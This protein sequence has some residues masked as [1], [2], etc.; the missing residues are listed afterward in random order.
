ML[1][2][3]KLPLLVPLVTAAMM[4]GTVLAG[5]ASA[6][7]SP[8]AQAQPA[9][10]RQVS[11]PDG[12]SIA[13]D[14]DGTATRTDAKGKVLAK[15]TLALPLGESALGESWAPTD[16]AVR[17]AFTNR[18]APS[19]VLAV[20][21]GNTAITGAPVAGGRRA[22][23]TS[24]AGLN[25]AF[26][27]VGAVSVQPLSDEPSLAK[28]F[29]VHLKGGDPAAA[30]KTL[31]ATP[32]IASAQPDRTISAMST[33]PV[34]FP[35]AAQKAAKAQSH[36]NPP[37]GLPDNYGLTSSAQSFLNAGGTDAVGAYSLLQNKF[38]QLP[39]TGEIITNVSI[40]DLT[41]QS[42]ADAGDAYVQQSGPT[43]I[44]QNGQRYLDLPSMP[45][46]PTYTSSPSGQLDPVG[47]A[48]NQDPSLGEV[49]LD[50]GVM[51][52]LPHDKQRPSAV[53]SGL[54]DLL[55]I[56]PGAQYRLVVPQQPTTDQIAVALMAAAR[57]NPRPNVITASLGF[58]T[59]TAGFPG[60][61]LEDDPVTQ[62]VISTIVRQYHIVVTISSNDGTRLYTPAAVGPDGGSTPTDTT[63]DPGATTDINDDATSTTPTKVLDS[64]AIAVGGTTLDDTIASS[65]QSGGALSRQGTFATT[66]TDGGELFSSGFG[67]RVDVS[68]P[69]D[70]ILVFEHTQRGA[71]QAVTPVLNGGTSASAPMTAAAAAVVLQASRLTGRTPSPEDVRSLLERTGRAVASPPQMDQQ[72]T[73]GKQIDVTAAVSSVLGGSPTKIQRLSVAHRVTK[74]GLGASF[75]EYT[76]PGRIDLV[77][78]GT[79]EGLVGP[80][81]IGA[82]VTGL[83]AFG[84]PDYVVRIGG[85]EFHSDTPAVRLTPTEMLQAAGLPVISTTDR[86]VQLTYQ[87]RFG[88]LALASEQKSLVFGPTDGTYAEAIAPVAPATVKAG[89]S[90][91]VHYDLTGV[92]NLSAPQLVV[93]TVGHWNPVSAPLFGA[94]YTAPLTA[95]SGDVTIPATAFDGGGGIYGLGIIQRSV[96]STTFG[97]PT[98]GEFTPIRVDGG[99]ASQRPDAPT[100]AA[101]GGQFGHN[102]EIPRAAPGFSL[103]Y[104]VR[105]IP[106]ATGAAVEVSAPAPTLYNALNTVTNANGTV[107]DNDGV[108][109]GSVAYQQLPGRSGTVSLD[110]VKLGLGSSLSYDV[111]VFPTGRDG[112]PVGQASPTSMLTL[113]DGLAPGGGRITSFAIQPGGT[114][115]AAVRDPSGSESLREYTPATGTFGRIL[116][117][118]A[119]PDDVYQVLGTDQ[120]AQRLAVLH[121]TSAG[122][123]VETYDTTSA[124][125]V[126]SATTSGYAVQGGR[127]DTVRHRAALLA[128]RTADN[129]DVVLPLT[130]SSGAIGAAILADGPGTTAGV[131][132]LLDLNQ[133]TGQVYLSKDTSG[134]ICFG[135]GVGAAVVGVNL[136]SGALLPAPS[137]SQCSG[138]LGIDDVANKVYQLPYRSFSVNIVGTTT[139]NP[140]D[141]A[142]LVSGP[143]STIRQQQAA[144]LAIDSV[145]HLALIAF[146]TPPVLS[147]FGR[148]GGVITDNN[149]TGQI[150]VTDPATG[151]QLSVASGLNFSSYYSGGEYNS[152]TERSIQ[153]EPANR[154]GWTLSADNTQIQQFHY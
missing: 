5:P 151:K 48:E 54:T 145:N 124:K 14:A 122:L 40:G 8:S 27:K 69:S 108:N 1:R 141:G 64:G 152:L 78:G 6:A 106:G 29:V 125:L 37:A 45:L 109:T 100:L 68:A 43:T 70:G 88:P 15:T 94:A 23:V 60:R 148:V 42:M 121:A 66:R 46:I 98:Y 13:V 84:R 71:A 2:A 132:R 128:K 101:S 138:S 58:G 130:L 72:I 154:T 140:L 90:V 127:V 110:A 139:L 22:A 143:V 50:F 147:I 89:G 65:P 144:H 30:A 91:K 61:Y 20:L 28:T 112:K 11:M 17:A 80:V 135:G 36:T 4:A 133:A 35:Q 119:S 85:H 39:G 115:A 134:L 116:A 104:D 149:A 82:D 92:K 76:D 95:T 44:V 81:T 53:G 107:R 3:H 52:P 24:D 63:R 73:V 113:D 79:G 12:G 150:A 55:G 59:D 111:R 34:P 56:A 67:S 131:Y 123:V 47:S 99:T 136:D 74:A 86:T 9:A 120:G 137:A 105:G 117:T 96:T 31:A 87:V 10:A 25:S 49:M 146:R 153:L 18:A 62:A 142:T 41:D 114:G 57:Q 75:T 26:A 32:G 16:D 77:S 126:A 118:D 103:R 97:S 38:G 33:G 21:A 7:P 93:S 51:A 129:A 102:L 19:D 83:P